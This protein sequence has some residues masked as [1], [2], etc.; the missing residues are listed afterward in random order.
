MNEISVQNQNPE[1]APYIKGRNGAFDITAVQLTDL[2]S[3]GYVWIDGVGKRGRPINGGLRVS[4]EMMDEL[5]VR[6]LEHRGRQVLRE[7]HRAPTSW[8]PGDVDARAEGLGYMLSESQVQEVYEWFLNDEDSFVEDGYLRMDYV[9]EVY[10]DDHDI[11]N[12]YADDLDDATED[13]S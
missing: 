3:T 2:S 12:I 7:G 10:T 6:W 11:P 5:A 13:A 1:V 9:I 4:P 8:T